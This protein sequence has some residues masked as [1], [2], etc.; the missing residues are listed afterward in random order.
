MGRLDHILQA[1]GHTPLIRLNRVAREVSS[2]IYL[3]AE[4]LNP[5]GSVKDRTALAMIEAAEESGELRPGATIVEATAGNTGVGLALAAAVKGYRLIVVLP[6]KM[7]ADKV[8]LL[9][10]FGAEVIITP[11]TVPPDSPESYNSVADRLAADI[12]GAFRPNQF[13]NPHNPQIHYRMTGPE[14]WE[15]S[16]GQVEVV[17]AGMGTGGTISGVGR[18][19]KEKNPQIVMV[20]ADPEGSVLSG[21]SPHS[22]KVEGIGEDFVPKTF[23]R[24]VV[25]EMIRI[26]DQDSF[27]TARRLARE[28]G[29]MVGGSTGTAVAAALRYAQRLTAP[30]FIVVIAPDTGRNYLAKFYREEW[31]R[32]NGFRV[33]SPP[34]PARVADLLSAKGP[35]ARLISV[36]PRN[37]LA[38]AIAAMQ[39]HAISQLPVIEN[40]RMVGSLSE[41]SVLKLLHDG[42]PLNREIAP[43]MAKPLPAVEETADILTAYRLLMAG[44]PAIVVQRGTEP[45]GILS[46][47]DLISAWSR[48]RAF[49]ATAGAAQ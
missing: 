19:L 32:E 45:L 27:D 42:T 5:G 13:A 38:D 26:S 10:A 28:E 47:I 43:L 33:A 22:Y 46:R 34:H 40:G 29:L 12:P 41:A 35:Q 30:R 18:F 48:G 17:V 9:R 49:A 23:H 16:N 6:D 20:G 11:T 24:P 25:D 14:I 31:L 2:P 21:D 44:A 39:T 7:S 36:G 4:F 37:T 8:D 15:D 3:K 1:I